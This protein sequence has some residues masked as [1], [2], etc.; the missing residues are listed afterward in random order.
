MGAA[1]AALLA[2][3]RRA[4]ASGVDAESALREATRLLETQVRAAE[5]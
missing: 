5:E 1:G 4:D 2:L 3:V